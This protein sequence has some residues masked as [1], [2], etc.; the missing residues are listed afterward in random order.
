MTWDKINAA[1]NPQ[2][3]MFGGLLVTKSEW[4]REVEALKSLEEKLQIQR[5]KVQAAFDKLETYRK[6]YKDL[7][8]TEEEYE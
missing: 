1:T 4:K 6:A 2:S 8:G 7:G 3:F 5:N